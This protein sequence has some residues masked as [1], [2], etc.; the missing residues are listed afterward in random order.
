M[1]SLSASQEELM[2]HVVLD[3]MAEISSNLRSIRTVLATIMT[4][5]AAKSS[6]VGYRSRRD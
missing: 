3:L 4:W 6:Y 5:M 2:V 1:P